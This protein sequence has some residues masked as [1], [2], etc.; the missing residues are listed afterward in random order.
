ALRRAGLPVAFS[1]GF[2][3]HPKVSWLGAAPTGTASLAE[4][5][6]IGLAESRD[7]GRVGADLDASLPAGLDVLGCVPASGGSLA[8]RVDASLWQIRLPAGSKRPAEAAVERFLGLDRCE[9]ERRTKDG[10]RQ[11]DARSAVVYALVEAALVEAFEDSDPEA[12]SGG[13]PGGAADC[14]C[15]ILSC[16]V[17]HTTPAVRPDDVLA[18]LRVAAGLEVAASM[19]TRLAQ[20]RWEG[21]DVIADPLAPD[22]MAAG[23]GDS[24]APECGPAAVGA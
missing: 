21:G 8:D 13:L 1:A 20:G 11:L 4:Y 22:V 9:V 6:E 15:A 10:R 16:V 7:P 14:D 24:A 2:T 19:A 18:A 5:V 23:E 3:P 12:G 17:R